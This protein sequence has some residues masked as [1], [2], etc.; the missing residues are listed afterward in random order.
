MGIHKFQERTKFK[1]EFYSVNQRGKRPE[2]YGGQ[3]N[4]VTGEAESSPVCNLDE[5]HHA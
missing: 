3:I 1:R 2:M 4:N 5:S